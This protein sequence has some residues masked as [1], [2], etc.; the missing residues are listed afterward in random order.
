MFK[1]FVEKKHYSFHEGF[2]DWR[3]AVRAACAPLLADGTIEKEYPEIIIEKV[4]ELGPYI[5]IAPNICI[6]HAERG[7][8]VNDTAMCFMKTEK[9]VSFDP[10]D[11]DK[12]ARIF[13]V[14]AATDDEVHLNNLMALSET[15]SDEDI[16]AKVLEAKT[17][18][19]LL[20]IE[21]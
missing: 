17:P 2:D 20:K 4:E 15:L 11:P 5:V 16:V 19:D 1:E 21:E 3:D 13:V 12:D 9:P 6:P 14:L 8:G 7:R 10:N 18:E